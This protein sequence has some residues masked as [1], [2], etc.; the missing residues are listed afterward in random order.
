MLLTYCDTWSCSNVFVAVGG[1]NLEEGTRSSYSTSCAFL[2]AGSFT[3]NS[4]IVG[5][6]A[7]SFTAAII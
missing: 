2:V 5:L 7:D 3:S 4:A 1:D 6:Y